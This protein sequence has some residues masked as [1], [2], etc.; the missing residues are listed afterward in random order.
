VVERGQKP[1][2][3]H[4]YARCEEDEAGDRASLRPPAKLPDAVSNPTRLGDLD[5]AQGACDVQALVAIILS[6]KAQANASI[7]VDCRTKGRWSVGIWPEDSL[8]R[9]GLA[10]GTCR[11]D[12]AQ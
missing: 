11:V 1:P 5:L 7:R 12:V 6:G 9:A 8:V 2:D 3:Q 10:D 4:D